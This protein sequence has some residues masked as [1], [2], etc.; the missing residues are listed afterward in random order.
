[1]WSLVPK[2]VADFTITHGSFPNWS[3][4]RLF[5]FLHNHK[6][7]KHQW[8]S[9]VHRLTKGTVTESPCQQSWWRDR[10]HPVLSVSC[11]ASTVM[12]MMHYAR[13]HAHH[14][15]TQKVILLT[16]V[17]DSPALTPTRVFISSSL[18]F[19]LRQMLRNQVYLAWRR[20]RVR[21][22]SSERTDT[23]G[24][25]IFSA[26][27]LLRCFA[28][29]VFCSAFHERERLDVW[30]FDSQVVLTG[31]LSPGTWHSGISSSPTKGRNAAAAGQ[32]I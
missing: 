3:K 11:P 19:W 7:A 25:D 2:V 27:D 29:Q 9:E 30:S 16:E 18:Q 8:S 1:M 5:E 17:T 32:L 20:A 6:D 28:E 13:C 22:T 4:V 14:T 21:A 26:L 23:Q 12:M 15:S 31:V 10:G 24:L